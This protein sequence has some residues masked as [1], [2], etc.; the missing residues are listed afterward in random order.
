MRHADHAEKA[1]SSRDLEGADAAPQEPSRPQQRCRRCLMLLGRASLECWPVLAVPLL[2]LFLLILAAI[3]VPKSGYLIQAVFRTTT[4]WGLVLCLLLPLGVLHLLRCLGA[5][6]CLL[7]AERG[8]PSQKRNT[9]RVICDAI[10]IVLC[11]LVMSVASEVAW[12][13]KCWDYEPSGASPET[14]ATSLHFPAAFRFGTATAAYQVEG[15]LNNSNWYDFEQNFQHADGSPAIQG[16][17]EV[18]LAA[19]V[20]N[21]FFEDLERLKDLHLETYRFS[22]SWSR[23]HPAKG[24]F[25]EEA[26]A[27]YRS[28]LIG[29]RNASIE[30]MVT[31][32]HY[33]EPIWISRQGSWTNEQT[34]EEWLQFVGLVASELGDL[35][36]LWMT[37]NEPFVMTGQAYLQALWPPATTDV[38]MWWDAMT[39]LMEA[40]K[41]GYRL[42]HDV[43]RVDADGDGRPA[44][45]SVAKNYNVFWPKSR[46]NIVDPVMAGISNMLVN[47]LYL[48]GIDGDNTLDWVGV[49]HYFRMDISFPAYVYHETSSSLY[50]AV[51]EVHGIYPTKQILVTEHGKS[52]SELHDPGRARYVTE[53]LVGLQLAADSGVPV[54]SYQYWALLDSWEWESGFWPRYGL[55]H[56]D[57][58][59]KAR[60]PRYFAMMYRNISSD[61]Q[62]RHDRT[63]S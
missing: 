14:L 23:L 32:L 12:S 31:L 18:G 28:W 20:W 21:L 41:R 29:L 26:L 6:C 55:Y 2:Y 33:D 9:R 53:S 62:A 34:V 13:S 47:K 37:Q 57:M 36:D 63:K 30:P 3:L 17:Q 49:N 59:T 56:V 52:E 39:N 7:R 11:Y 22:I 8:S 42:V 44:Q 24:T 19:D 5:G 40:H 27:R 50:S 45:V 10:T 1:S 4:A 60:T 54:V 38:S 48:G 46:W 61:H 25:D 15:G 16:H 35:V 43:D 58:S 51:C